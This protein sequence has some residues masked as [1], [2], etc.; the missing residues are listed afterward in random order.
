MLLASRYQNI[1]IY[2]FRRTCRLVSQTFC[3]FTLC[4]KIEVP[5][6][7]LAGL[8]LQGEGKD[9]IALLDCVLA[10]GVARGESAVD[11]VEGL[12][13]WECSC[14]HGKQRM[15]RVVARGFTVLERHLVTLQG[16][17]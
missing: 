8:V 14:Q 7:C 15:A 5:A 1:Y 11:H 4:P 2:I 6:F 10:L 3:D 16:I 17:C 12:G 13:G 9:G